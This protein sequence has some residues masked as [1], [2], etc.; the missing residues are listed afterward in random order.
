MGK[1][2]AR[3]PTIFHPVT[4]SPAKLLLSCAIGI[5]LVFFAAQLAGLRELTCVLNGTVGSISLGW[6]LS[7][8]LA[9]AYIFIYLAFV[10]LVPVFML[11]SG[12]LFFW[13]KWRRH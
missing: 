3:R 8:I 13:Q 5:T 12:F 7:E 1:F 10:I 11:A 6:Q 2:F 4:F 9:L